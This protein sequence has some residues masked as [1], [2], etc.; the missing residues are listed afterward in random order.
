MITGRVPGDGKGDAVPE[1]QAEHRPTLRI[2]GF[3]RKFDPGSFVASVDGIELIQASRRVIVG[4]QSR[5]DPTTVH[6]ERRPITR[7]G[8]LPGGLTR[9]CF[10]GLSNGW[11]Y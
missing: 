9:G 1:A 4:S 11:S 5:E 8:A 7:M 3:A 6:L 10:W 2:E